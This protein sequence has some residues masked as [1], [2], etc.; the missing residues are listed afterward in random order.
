MPGGD[1]P[2]LLPRVLGICSWAKQCNKSAARFFPRANKERIPV[3][4][5][6]ERRKRLCNPIRLCQ[7]KRQCPVLPFR[8][9]SLWLER[10][11]RVSPRISRRCPG[12]V[13]KKVCQS[14]IKH[15]AG[16]PAG[17]GSRQRILKPSCTERAQLKCKAVWSLA[18]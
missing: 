3:L 4:F 5:R 16:H 17:H 1:C 18:S 7:P 8:F 9:C 12:T 6:N 2:H 11:F 13:L 15:G 14:W 10:G